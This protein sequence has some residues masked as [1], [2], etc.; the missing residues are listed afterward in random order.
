MKSISTLLI[1]FLLSSY[2]SSNFYKEGISTSKYQRDLSEC[3]YLVDQ[4]FSYQAPRSDGS[5]ASTSGATGS[6][7]GFLIGR[8]MAKPDRMKQRKASKGYFKK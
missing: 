2:A 1:L 4:S 6:A 8:A 5:M 3:E 7:L